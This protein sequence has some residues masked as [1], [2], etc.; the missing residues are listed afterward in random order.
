MEVLK[1]I[2]DLKRTS[3]KHSKKHSKKNSQRTSKNEKAIDKKRDVKA[4]KKEQQATD[5]KRDHQSDQKGAKKAKS[6]SYKVAAKNQMTEIHQ[7]R[8]H[9]VVSAK[10]KVRFAKERTCKTIHKLCQEYFVKANRKW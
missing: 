3:K 2:K 10:D 9:N 4:A 7:N 6:N 8:G 1:D 5:R